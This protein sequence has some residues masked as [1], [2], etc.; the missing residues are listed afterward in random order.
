MKRLI[1]VTLV[2]TLF[3]SAA[4]LAEILYAVD[5][6]RTEL[7]G[8]SDGSSPRVDDVRSDS[9]KLSV[10]GDEKA[11]K[12]WVEFDISAVDVGALTSAQLRLTLYEPKSGSCLVSVVNDDVTSGYVPLDGVITWN[13]AP[14]NIT[15]ADGINPDNGSFSAGDLQDNLDPALTSLVG[16]IDYSGGAEGQQFVI[17]VLSA[18]QADTDG[19]VLF[20]LHGSS[21]YMNWTT[22]DSSG[23]LKSG[24][25][26]GADDVHPA[27]VLVPEPAT[28]L[29]LGLGG[30]AALRRKR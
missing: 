22:H 12:S 29:L 20:A 3:V 21:G 6:S 14:G 2:S 17:D 26:Y 16:T 25:D 4:S 5:S 11:N 13:T 24:A 10:R 23:I 28:M 19:Y 1:L 15:S 27:L 30:L 18:L 8:A 9:S 7:N